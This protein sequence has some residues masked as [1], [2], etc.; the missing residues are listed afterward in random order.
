MPV[1][2]SDGVTYPNRCSMCSKMYEMKEKGNEGYTLRVMSNGQCGAVECSERE[3]SGACTREYAPVCGSD[4]RTYSNKCML[5][6]A[7][8]N[9]GMELTMKHR[10]VCTADEAN[11]I[12][13]PHY[14]TGICT[15]E[16]VPICGSDGKDYG[17]VCEYCYHMYQKKDNG[18][19][20]TISHFGECEEEAAGAS[21]GFCLP[22][23][24]T[25]MCT[26]EYMPICGSDGKTYSNKCTFCYAM[27]TK[28]DQNE[29]LDMT[30]FGACKEE[31]EKVPAHTNAVFCQP[32]YKS[33]VCTLEYQ[34]FCG[35]DGKTYG[36]K[37]TFCYA[38]YEK[39][40]KGNTLNIR[41]EGECQKEDVLECPAIV[42][43]GIC[44]LEYNPVCGSDGKMYS[45]PCEFCTEQ[46]KQKANGVEIYFERMGHCLMV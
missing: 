42:D 12:C 20:I 16:Y 21:A 1:C 25:G 45:N 30:H 8:Q 41:R 4:G 31:E 29:E 19:E 37:C 26:R 7:M 9:L 23:Y 24:K 36:N 28:M 5:C 13:Q 6:Y 15:R 11:S 18:E 32:Q 17:N 43:E 10:G 46:K 44:T 2:A 39:S 27:Y 14:K 22:Q 38:M 33:G 40:E 35:S 34:P 3:K